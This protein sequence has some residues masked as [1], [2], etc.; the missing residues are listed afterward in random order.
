MRKIALILAGGKGTRLWPLSRENY[1]KQFVEFKG[2]QSLFQ[3]TLDR[4]L[5]CFHP[6]DIY[7]V[8]SEKYKFTILNQIDFLAK[9]DKR[10]KKTLKANLIFEPAPKNTA[11]SV[12]LSIKYL[13]EHRRLSDSLP[14]YVFP[15]D[16]IIE[17]VGR[18]KAV[19]KKAEKLSRK[20]QV[21]VFGV[22]PKYPKEGY[23]YI[24]PKKRSSSVARFVEKPG[25]AKA[26][27]LLKAGAL[28]NSGIFCFRKDV[29]LSE[30]KKYKPRM[31]AFYKF[32]YKGMVKRFKE[33]PKDSIDYAI[34]QKT[35]KASYVRFDLTWSDLGS[36]DSLLSLYPDLAIGKVTSL[37]SHNCF[38]YS[39]SRLVSLVGLKD[40]VV[41][42]SP[43]SL[44][45]VKKG[46]SD[47]VK[48]LVEILGRK[49]EPAIKDSVTVYRPW[50]Y[51]TVLKEQ[52]GY[53]KV[54]EIG[55]YPKKYISLQRHKY[56]SEHWNVVEG[57]GQI[58]LGKKRKNIRKNESIYVDK[59]QLHKV[60]N[61]GDK[62]LKMIEVQIGN[63]LG[64]DDIKRFD[65]YEQAHHTRH[66]DTRTQRHT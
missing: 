20:G 4:T 46:L 66:K 60:Y 56:R 38:V 32:D 30:L 9:S 24:I 11:P 57:K 10:T 18:L 53:Y 45:V 39:K 21:V 34:M 36:W 47:R 15:S 58:I 12:L 23:G 65:S 43:D 35:R 51:Y 8:S 2:G 28:W 42:D 49:K 59:G 29:F 44:L 64:E 61:P 63:Y 41:V 62:T 37:D 40:V 54:K 55:V 16:H 5:A 22:P 1:P 25:L 19:L 6:G 27:N 3:L 50:G 17:P 48:E 33:I 31:H 14:L 13:D 7:V 26:K 52:K